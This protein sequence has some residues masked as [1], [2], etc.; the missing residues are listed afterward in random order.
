VNLDKEDVTVDDVAGLLKLFFRMLPNPLLTFELYD[1]FL[2]A[3][4][5]PVQFQDQRLECMKQVLDLLPPGNW[6][7]VS[8]LMRFLTLVA[9]QSEVN[10]MSKQNLSIVFAPSLMRALEEEMHEI[11]AAAL[12]MADRYAV[13]GERAVCF[14]CVVCACV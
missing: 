13:A 7:I 6:T 11:T 14:L 3:I 10:K 1:C 9:D 8:F 4:G 12:S 2:A 5:I